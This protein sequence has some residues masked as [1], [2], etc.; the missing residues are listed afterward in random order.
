MGANVWVVLGGEMEMKRWEEVG[1]DF[2]Q[3]TIRK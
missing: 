1:S 2:D 3:Q